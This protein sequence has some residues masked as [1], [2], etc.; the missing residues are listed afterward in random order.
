MITGDYHLEVGGDYSQKIGGNVRT[1]IGAKAGGGN[2]MQEI[3]GSY[4]FDISG[5]YIGSVG[6]KTNAG[7]GEGKYK[8]TIVGDE[9]IKVGGDAD[10]L[11][12]GD[13]TVA[14]NSDM[15]VQITEDYAVKTI[16]GILSVQS[17][18]TFEM[19][20]L[21]S[22]TILSETGNIDIDTPASTGIIEL[23]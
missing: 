13:I 4:G 6:P 3:R 14:G 5:D 18:T 7:S 15:T 9:D 20:S 2:L 12:T 17:G 22:I 11:V 8:L 1:K 10:Y 19:K 16:S 21:S 23:N